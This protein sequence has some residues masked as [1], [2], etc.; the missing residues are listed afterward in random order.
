MT[1]VVAHVAA[2]VDA[3][4]AA[5]QIFDSWV[6]ALAP[7]TYEA[8]V[9][10]HM[11][12]LFEAI[13]DLGV[14]V[15]HFGVGTGEL[16]GAMAAA[17]GD[18]IGID[19]RVPLDAGWDRVGGPDRRAVQGNLDPACSSRRGMWSSTT[20]STCSRAPAVAMGTSSTS[21]TACCPTHRWSTCSAW[22]TWCTSGPSGAQ[23]RERRR[24]GGRRR[25]HRA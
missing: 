17:G 1:I 8:A 25:R 11:R 22:S 13:G 3:G 19:A 24:R 15:I 18:A 23:R 4:A 5:I 7:V 16:L 20:R 10:P 2:Q 6:G 21:G 9:A 14:P 12:R